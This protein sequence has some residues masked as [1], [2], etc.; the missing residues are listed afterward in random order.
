M[1]WLCDPVNGVD[2]V[3]SSA[4]G[5]YATRSITNVTS[6][7][8][9]QITCSA[10]HNLN[11]GDYV[12]L[13][14][15]GGVAGLNT[16]YW[17]ITYVDAT[18]FTVAYDSTLDTY[19]SGGTAFPYSATQTNP[20][21][22]RVADADK[23]GVGDKL[24]LSSITGMTQISGSVVTVTALHGSY[25]LE[26]GAVDAT[27]YGA[28]TGGSPVYS[29]NKSV[30]AITKAN[31]G[32]V[33]CKA[34]GFSNGD[35]VHV[36]VS[37]TVMTEFAAGKTFTVANATTDTFELSGIDTTSWTGT[38][39]GDAYISWA[40]KYLES[41]TTY[42][43]LRDAS[44]Y[45]N[46]GGDTLKV[47]E[48]SSVSQLTAANCTWT[49][50]SNTVST[51]ASLS[52]S[53]AV[54]DLVSRS[55]TPGNGNLE[56][57]YYVTARTG[58]TITLASDYAGTTGTD[59]SSIYKI[60]PVAA[61]VSGQSLGVSDS[62][63]LISGG[64][65]AADNTQLARTGETWV[66][67]A[68]AFTTSSNNGIT[69]TT[70]GA[71]VEYM[72]VTNCYRNF[73]RTV[74]GDI[75]NCTGVYSR[76][77]NLDL[78]SDGATVTNCSF[79]GTSA[80]NYPAIYHVTSQGHTYVNSQAIAFSSTAAAAVQSNEAYAQQD[81]DG[82]IMYGK[83]YGL[84][85]SNHSQQVSNIDARNT[86]VGVYV[87]TAGTNAII[88]GCTFTNTVNYG[89]QIGTLV[90][91]A[92]VIDPQF[93]GS[94]PTY[95]IYITQS[96]GIKIEGG[97]F[98]QCG[99]GVYLDQYAANVHIRDSHFGTPVSYGINKAARS[100]T[101]YV[102]GCT[103]DEGSAGKAFFIPA[104]NGYNEPEYSIL[105]SFFGITGLFYA[106]QHIV[107]VAANP[108]YTSFQF[109]SSVNAAYVDYP[110]IAQA[111]KRG[112]SPTIDFE[113]TR[114]SGTAFSG[115]M[116]LVVRLNGVELT[117][118]VTGN[119]DITS[120]SAHDTWDAKSISVSS[121]D[122]DGLL[123]ICFKPALNTTNIPIWIRTNP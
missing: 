99:T 122:R 116:S 91:S 105:D 38:Y 67:H 26:I 33:T 39:N 30:Q 34:H 17:Q 6:A 115:T 62:G 45:L 20:L 118:G 78:T 25:T 46:G 106:N 50:G 79:N 66:K 8:N 41:G 117:S 35:M 83:G 31:P 100:S 49:S 24:Y 42:Q 1:D 61:G 98:A 72:N 71:G 54:G 2:R 36:Q 94:M 57:A 123:T 90:E 59:T 55:S 74:T 51:S 37:D 63:N 112:E 28:Y 21:R 114:P 76:I 82:L 95:G 58:T 48:T 77:Y 88:N 89:V 22:I 19:I 70:D 111:V 7:A 113:I 23:F 53:I 92:T 93:S 18:N 64:W 121:V 40:W 11:T 5:T 4:M 12:Y 10:A 103:I 81:F 86:T 107:R 16:Q 84:R 87:E 13:N 3:V 68:G 109:N 43:N 104:N 73:Y 75:T 15:I 44:L 47:L 120:I 108:P 110:V 119:S 56:T 85:L 102:E 29:F 97:D 32:V 52:A 80:N 14:A 101:V 27:S 69:L 96:N 60:V 9:A 65:V